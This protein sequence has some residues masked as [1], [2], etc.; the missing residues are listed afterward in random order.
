MSLD[1]TSAT[2]TRDTDGAASTGGVPL[3]RDVPREETWDLE[4]VFP[5]TEAWE[6]AY[7]AAEGRLQDPERF[8]GRLG[9]SATV[10]LAGLRLRDELQEAVGRVGTFAF[11]RW[12]EDSTNPDA[13]ALAER[14]SGLATRFRSAIAFYDAELL[15]LPRERIQEF[16]AAEPGLAPYRHALELVQRMREHIRS[17]EVEEVLAQASDL[18]GVPR[19]IHDV[20]EKGELPF[21]TIEDERGTPVPL[22]QS[23][24]DRFLRSA[25]RRVRREAWERSADAYL[26]LQNTFAATLAGGV[27]RD[28][29]Y[30][31]AR[32]YASCLEAALDPHA[33]P[34]GV[35]HNLLE[36]VWANLPVW[37]RYFRVRRRLL[38]IAEGDLRGWDLT[39]PLAT[40]P[41]DLPWTEGVELVLASLAPLGDA[42]VGIVRRGLDERWVDRAA[43]AGKGGGAFSWGSYRT[44]PFISMVYRDDLGSVSTLTHELGHSL[45][46]YHAWEG[47]PITYWP[48]SMFTAETA[49]NMHQALLGTHLLEASQERDWTLAVIEERMANHL[50]YLFTMPILARFE[51]DCHEKAERGEALTAAGMNA[52]LLEL[53]RQG[54]GGEVVLDEPRMGITWA[55]FGHLFTGFYVF[56][57]ATGISAAAAL[58]A[59][60]QE[61]GAPAAE[62]YVAFLRQG[63]A[64][65]PID[66]LREAGVDMTSPA[67]VQ[68][69]FDIL[70][71]YVD[72]LEELAR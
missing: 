7:Q 37:H 45:H 13:A 9:E 8:R 70:S 18:A 12:A 29:F 27:K 68:A 2:G 33:I 23:N 69:A 60:V 64:G 34:A 41:P 16:L 24:L 67:P 5:T 42:Y 21:S 50:R 46:S 66:L 39:A 71:G 17:A 1:T 52:T 22:A 61:E 14:G 19:T 3:R 31:R 62:R 48:Y 11:L 59:K 28:V 30:A 54:Y 20:L 25:D 26:A 36:T 4:R 58:A 40:N 32:G 63:G 57:Y 44:A 56:Q 6:E 10:L 53:Y 15:A 51:L 38:G 72:R 65:D 55:R 35:F 43:N 47:Q 49:S